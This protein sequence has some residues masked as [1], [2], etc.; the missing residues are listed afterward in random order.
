MAKTPR[1]YRKELREVFVKKGADFSKSHVVEGL[2]SSLARDSKKNLSHSL[3]GDLVETATDDGVDLPDITRLVPL[4]LVAVAGIAAGVAGTKIA[5][6]VKSK[7][8]E[9]TPSIAMPAGWYA[10]QSQPDLLR[11]W[12]GEGWT[13]QEARREQAAPAIAADWYPD[14]LGGGH[15]RYWDGAAWTHHVAALPAAAPA[16]DWY[17]DPSDPSRTRYWDGAAWTDH[18]AAVRGAHSTS[19]AHGPTSGAHGSLQHAEPRPT[20]SA[21]EWRAHVEAWARAGAIH[22]EL[23]QRLTTAEIVDAD[24]ETLSAHR[25]MREL[26]PEE[27]AE[28]V[29]AMIAASPHLASPDSLVEFVR[30]FAG[31][32]RRGLGR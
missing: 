20:M 18:V 8:A 12:D 6:N 21:A 23:W 32:G 9:S 27:G 13:G 10:D 11:Y 7:R 19:S 30:L 15:V 29:R 4:G 22:S 17:P 1:G 14:P 5:Q 25:A 24:T 3:I 2:S 26:T 28:Q 31:T 16:A